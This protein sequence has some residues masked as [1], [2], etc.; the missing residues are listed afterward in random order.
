MV[1][2]TP[3]IG[4]TAMTLKINIKDSWIADICSSIYIGNNI[5]KFEQYKEIEPFQI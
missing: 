3:A 4:P 5:K 1:F 2:A